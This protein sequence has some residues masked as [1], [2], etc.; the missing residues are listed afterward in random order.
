MVIA[1]ADVL[2]AQPVADIVHLHTHPAVS[3]LAAR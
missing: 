2:A 3:V 1:L